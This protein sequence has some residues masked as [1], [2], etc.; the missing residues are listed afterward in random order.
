MRF[1]VQGESPDRTTRYELPLQ[2]KVIEADDYPSILGEWGIDNRWSAYE[3][4]NPELFTEASVVFGSNDSLENA[5]LLES[6]ET[7]YVQTGVAESWYRLVMPEDRNRAELDMRSEPGVIL[8]FELLDNDG[9]L[10]HSGLSDGG[11]LSLNG[12]P[13]T[14]WH[15]R[16]WEPPRSVLFAWDTSGSVRPYQPQTYAALER[17]AGAIRGDLE[18]V[19]LLAFHTT[20]RFLLPEWSS[21]AAEVSRIINAY[22]RTDDSSD[23]QLNLLAASNEISKRDGVRA[24]VL[25]TDAETGG[26]RTTPDLWDSLTRSGAQVYS[27][28]ISTAGRAPAQDLMQ[29]W[30]SANGGHYVN[31]TGLTEL[32]QG[33]ARADCLIRRAKYVEVSVEFQ[34]RAAT[35]GSLSVVRPADSVGEGDSVLTASGGILVIL[36]SSGSMYRTLDGRYRYEIAKDVL[37]DLVT[38]VL[39]AEVPFALRVFGNREANICRSDLEVGLAPLDASAVAAVIAG[40]EPQPFAGTPIADS[41]RAATGDLADAAGQRTVILITDG[42]ESCDGDVEAAIADLR[43]A[44]FDVT[45]NIIGFDFDADDVDAAREQFRSWAELGGG[46]YF[47]AT[48]AAELAGALQSSV[49]LPY[50]VLNADGNLI[51]RGTVNGSGI[52]LD[53]GVYTVRVLSEEP[54]VF[55][56]VSVDGGLITLSLE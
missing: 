33:F 21:D 1:Q 45:L 38:D 35:P 5:L 6:T 22:D 8:G 15:L 3:H 12:E 44:G 48:S 18:S 53:G 54:V 43:S 37:A 46:Q 26:Y 17:F 19:M 29:D 36:D 31:A 28:E 56:D 40:I 25:I 42:E 49:T 10:V 32:E 27:L 4:S 30:A 41:L 24:I 16:I 11:Q 50:E 7:G 55:N 51:A 14:T 52:D 34:E 23:A 20:P 2:L 9:N 47:D 39:P 13:G